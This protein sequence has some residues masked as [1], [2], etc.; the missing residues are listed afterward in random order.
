MIVDIGTL[1]D[2]KRDTQ[3]IPKT[4]REVDEEEK[5]NKTKQKNSFSLFTFHAFRNAWIRGNFETYSVQHM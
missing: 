4:E 2:E 1:R 5:Q 3:Q